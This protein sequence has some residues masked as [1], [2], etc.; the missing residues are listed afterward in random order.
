MAEEGAIADGRGGGRDCLQPPP[1]GGGAT[2]RV[3]GCQLPPPPPSKGASGQQLVGGGG[4]VGV[5]NRGVA[6]PLG[7]NNVRMK[8]IVSRQ[9]REPMAEVGGG[10]ENG[11]ESTP[12]PPNPILSPAQSHRNG[13]EMAM[14]AV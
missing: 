8:G 12:I 14:K 5:Q 4:G 2:P 1:G 11:L 7:S 3:L 9:T 10:L 13:T 6:P